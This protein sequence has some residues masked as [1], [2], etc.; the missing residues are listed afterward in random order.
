LQ[1]YPLN[2]SCTKETFLKFHVNY[3]NK[4]P[5]FKHFKQAAINFFHKTI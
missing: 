2:F 1:C 5:G 4:L 3:F